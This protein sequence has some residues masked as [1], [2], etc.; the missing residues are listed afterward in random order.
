M[1][2]NRYGAAP[3]EVLEYLN[4]H[5]GFLYLFRAVDELQSSGASIGRG[6]VHEE[7]FVAL[8][9]ECLYDTSKPKALASH[10]PGIGHSDLWDGCQ[11]CMA[12]LRKREVTIDI[13]GA[14]AEGRH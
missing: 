5:A 1:P 8:A 14:L 6:R 12:S 13:A 10:M 3:L 9:R 7:I 4:L 11:E 2:W